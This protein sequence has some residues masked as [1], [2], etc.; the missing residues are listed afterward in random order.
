MAA[1]EQ[2]HHDDTDVDFAL[3]NK[4]TEDG[5]GFQGLDN[6]DDLPKSDFDGFA[7]DNV[8]NDTDG[9]NAGYDQEDGK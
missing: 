1:V 5:P 7:E 8:E 6:P 4:T 3:K 9:D 2:T